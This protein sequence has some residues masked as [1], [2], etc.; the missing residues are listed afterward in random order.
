VEG[1]L[2]WGVQVILWLQGGS[3]LLDLPFIAITSLGA[4]EFLLVVMAFVF[5]CVDRRAG[6]RLAALILISAWL[7][8]V[9]KEI[10]M[11]P[12]PFEWDQQVRMIFRQRARPAQRTH[13]GTVVLWLSGADLPRRRWL[14][15]LAAILML[16]VPLSRLYLGVHFPTGF[17]GRL[18]AGCCRSAGLPA[19]EPPVER[20]LARRPLS[21]QCLAGRQPL[22]C[23]R[24]T[25]PPPMRW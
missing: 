21:F 16:L 20:W 10:A 6:A 7:N 22:A 5:W 11:Q 18:P 25:H 3:P 12:R 23:G 14:S 1:A 19:L 2:N 15:I 17:A 4:E 8:A 24:A 9:A 13:P